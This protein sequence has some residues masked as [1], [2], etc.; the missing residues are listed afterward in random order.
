VAWLDDDTILYAR[1]RDGSPAEDDTWQVPA[2]G[3]GEA[4]LFVRGSTS[5]SVARS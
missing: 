2:D 3:T 1:P 5:L 4:R